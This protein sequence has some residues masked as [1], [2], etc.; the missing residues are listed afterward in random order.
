M[1]VLAKLLMLAMEAL[2]LWLPLLLFRTFA[3]MMAQGRGKQCSMITIAD[4]H[5]R[6]VVSSPMGN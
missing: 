5:G 2:V 6:R 4:E 3:E 1:K